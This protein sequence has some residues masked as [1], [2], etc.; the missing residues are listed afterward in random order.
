MSNDGWA[1]LHC[2]PLCL[3][4]GQPEICNAFKEVRSGIRGMEVKLGHSIILN[5]KEAEMM[6]ARDDFHH[7][8]HLNSF[9][10][11]ALHSAIS[12]LPI[13]CPKYLIS[14]LPLQLLSCFN[15][16]QHTS[17]PSLLPHEKQR[18]YLKRNKDAQVQGAYASIRHNY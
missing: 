14:S 7:H 15:S 8:H 5:E 4:R 12:S 6:E 1:N 10:F 13:P 9:I 11:V 16:I 3:K 2:L 17:R 18:Q